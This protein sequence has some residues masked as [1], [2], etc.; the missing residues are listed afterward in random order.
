M[1]DRLVK[2]AG[3]ENPEL[4][5]RKLRAVLLDRMVERDSSITAAVDEVFETAR[6]RKRRLLS[7]ASERGLL[8]PSGGAVVPLGREGERE[9]L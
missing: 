9:R 8:G 6:S 5:L 3:G 1:H 2:I 4:D 7:G